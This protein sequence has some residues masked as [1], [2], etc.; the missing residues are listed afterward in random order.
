MSYKISSTERLKKSGSDAETKAM[1]YLM[2]FREDSS[3]IYF[4]IIDFF[5]DI[6]GMDR[7][8][9]KLWDIQS[10]ANIANSPKVIGRE[11][12]TLFKNYNSNFNFVEYILFIGGVPETFRKDSSLNLFNI[13]NINDKAIK[14]LKKGLLEESK[15]KE[16]INNSDIYDSNI[17]NFLKRVWFVVNDKSP[18]EYIKQ[19]LSKYSSIVPEDSQLLAIFN[20]IRN[21]Q[22]EKKNTLV[23]GIIINDIDEALCYG[24]HLTNHE[25]KLLVLQRIINSDP[26][27]KDIPK[28]FLN[29]C[30]K[31]PPE[32]IDNLIE[33][34]QMSLT[35]ALFNK[36]TAQGFWMLFDTIYRSILEYPNKDINFIFRQ[37][38]DN[39]IDACPDFDT[40]SLKYFIAKI[41]G[42]ICL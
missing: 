27:S 33:S 15:N 2:N 10:K 24:R 11:L 30:S 12:V 36:S 42:G 39:V 22:S 19:I 26:L 8:S 6:T 18:E 37:I 9:R 23:E 1:L 40:L 34:C 13:E 29:I 17:D 4:F 5:N 14:S 38:P 25:I 41:K 21:K 31:Y 20:E 28:Y 7:M 35:R 16:Y 3:E 32:S